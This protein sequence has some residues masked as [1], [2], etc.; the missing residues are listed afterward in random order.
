MK[1]TI[2]SL[3][4]WIRCHSWRRNRGPWVALRRS[5][6]PVLSWFSRV[7]P[8]QPEPVGTRRRSLRLW[9]RTSGGFC[10]TLGKMSWRLRVSV[11]SGFQTAESIQCGCSR[12]W[13]YGRFRDILGLPSFTQLHTGQG[14]G[15]KARVGLGVKQ[16][17]LD[18]GPSPEF[19]AR[20][21]RP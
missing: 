21:E 14:T 7:L 11:V 5:F 8:C 6:S 20:I 10:E 1:R 18:P 17:P 4:E 2:F 13:S 3:R 12:I 15:A 19:L 9:I 16:C